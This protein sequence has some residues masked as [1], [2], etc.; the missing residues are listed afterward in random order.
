MDGL[1]ISGAIDRA[2]VPELCDRARLAVEDSDAEIV[3][4]DV[5]A[6]AVP[7]AVA[8]DLLARLHLISKRLGRQLRL[9]APQPCLLELIGLMGLSEVLVVEPR[10]QPE[11]REEVLGIEEEADPADGSV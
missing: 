10:G 6:I 3:S 11:E 9:V 4:C 8:V 5:R 1:V 7:D 2:R